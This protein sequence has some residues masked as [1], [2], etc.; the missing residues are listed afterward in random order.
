MEHATDAIQS[1]PIASTYG[2]EIK[3]DDATE[4]NYEKLRDDQMNTGVIAA[5][6]GGFALTNSWEMDV[7][8]HTEDSECT[9][10]GI[11][12]YCLAIL[13]VHACTCSA[14]VSAFLYRSL[15]QQKTC[16]KGVEWMQRHYV[17]EHMPWYFFLMGTL[18][19]VVSVCLVAWS[20]LEVSITGR[21]VT[22]AGGMVSCA[23]LI[24][25]CYVI[26]TDYD[27]DDADL[28]SFS[29]NRK[30]GKARK[31]MKSRAK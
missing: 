12:S 22:I 18:F 4:R 15:T 9:K 11:V 23:V 24:Y 1:E 28:K 2:E 7:A 3:D 29:T 6:L 25:T 27:A 10:I 20:T 14:L 13:A 8:Q 31:R 17:L 19:Y 16:R 30:T 26:I 5:L 21:V